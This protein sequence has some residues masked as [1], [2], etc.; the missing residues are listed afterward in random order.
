MV[1]H[2]RY[3]IGNW[4]PHHLGWM[5]MITSSWIKWLVWMISKSELRLTKLLYVCVLMIDGWQIKWLTCNLLTDY[6]AINKTVVLGW[7]SKVLLCFG[8]SFSLK[9]HFSR[10]K[11]EASTNGLQ[12]GIF[13]E[14]QAR[15]FSGR[16][17]HT[18][19]A[20]WF[21]VLLKGSQKLFS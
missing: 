1:H 8:L 9:W 10:P 15:D 19:A 16:W 14:T 11:T 17:H 13:F 2:A 7:N 18:P 4:L 21:P 3:S 20:I 12:S 6:G 5:C